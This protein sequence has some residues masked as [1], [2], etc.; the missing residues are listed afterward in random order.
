M[1]VINNENNII[2]TNSLVERSSSGFW[3]HSVDTDGL[4]AQTQCC[5]QN[6]RQAMMC[7]SKYFSSE[8]D[9]PAIR[10]IYLQKAL[11]HVLILAEY[12]N[13]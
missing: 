13:N 12:S 5:L 10:S 7:S 8:L 9:F 3:D 11:M 4:S 2:G 1:K 6:S